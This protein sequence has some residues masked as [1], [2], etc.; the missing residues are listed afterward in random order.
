MKPIAEEELQAAVVKVTE[1]I[2]Q[3]R[4]SEKFMELVKQ[5]DDSESGLSERCVFQ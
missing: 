3:K 4:K 1:E 5:P 2:K